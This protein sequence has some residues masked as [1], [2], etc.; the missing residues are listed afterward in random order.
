ML[1]LFPL[2]PGNDEKDQIHKIHNILGTPP[3]EILDRFQRNATHIDFNFPHAIGTGIVPLIPHVN[4]ECQD[5]ISKLLAYNPDER[6]TARQALN[7][8][9]FKELRAQDT[10]LPAQVLHKEGGSPT[11]TG[12]E[13][14]IDGQDAA[15][16][17]STKRVPKPGDPQEYGYKKKMQQGSKKNPEHIIDPTNEYDDQINNVDTTLLTF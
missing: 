4:P 3:R 7:S 13:H 6:I 15:Y 14:S 12:D 10:K 1:S 16:H 5:M 17:Q 11:S 9:Y 8:P 2:F